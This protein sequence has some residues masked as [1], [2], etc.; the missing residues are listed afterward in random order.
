MKIRAIFKQRNLDY[1]QEHADFHDQG[2]PGIDNM[3][4]NWEQHF[5]SQ[6]I[7]N[8]QQFD[9][10]D[11]QLTGAHEESNEE[12]IITLKNMVAVTYQNEKGK[13]NHYAV[14]KSLLSKWNF[15]KNEKQNTLSCYFYFKQTEE[16]VKLTDGIFIA[17]N[18]IPDELKK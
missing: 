17:I 18:E 7:E 9:Q 11:I 4:Y 5:Q 3:K 12:F 15:T 14:S 10:T 13:Q 16:F 2:Q 8:A 6:N 1:S